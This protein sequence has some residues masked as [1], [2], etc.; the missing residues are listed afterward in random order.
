MRYAIDV[1]QSIY[2][3]QG[4]VF[5]YGLS[6]PS[7]GSRHFD[8]QDPQRQRSAGNVPSCRVKVDNRASEQGRLF[9]DPSHHGCHKCVPQENVG[10]RETPLKVVEEEGKLVPTHR[11]EL[12]SKLEKLEKYLHDLRDGPDHESDQRHLL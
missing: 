5:S 6:D 7:G 1:L 12:K 4:D 3:H 10:H 9:A 11:L 8:E 2:K